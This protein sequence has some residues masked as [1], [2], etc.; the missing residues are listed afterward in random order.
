MVLSIGVPGLEP[1]WPEAKIR[2]PARIPGESVAEADIPVGITWVRWASAGAAAMRLETTR[3][4]MRIRSSRVE[5]GGE[6]RAA[7]LSPQAVMTSGALGVLF[8]RDALLP[9]D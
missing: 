4:A 2:S 7:R 1:S 9:M 3:V 8:Y 5:I 6:G